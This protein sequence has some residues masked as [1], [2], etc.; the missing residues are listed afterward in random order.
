MYFSIAFG[1]C[2]LNKILNEDLKLVN[3]NKG[4]YEVHILC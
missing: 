3:W 4:A 1:Q 2:S